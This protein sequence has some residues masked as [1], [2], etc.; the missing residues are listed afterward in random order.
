MGK[1]N[2]I[3]MMTRLFLITAI[4]LMVS[5]SEK[6]N[7]PE[8]SQVFESKFKTSDLKNSPVKLIPFPQEVEW[9]RKKIR[10]KGLNLINSDFKNPNIE[11]ELD[12]IS[13]E[14]GLV[15]DIGAIDL[16][17]ILNSDIQN[18]GYHLYVDKDLILIESSSYAGVFYTLQTLR[19][20]IDVRDGKA[21]IQACI[22]KDY[23][24]FQIRGYMLDVGR[25]YQSMSSL[26]RQLDIMARYKLNVFH[27]HLTDRPAWRIESKIYPELTA[28]EN[29]RPTRDPGKFYSYEEI[30]EL[31]DY[32]K[33]L[34]I[35]VIP[36]IDMPGHSDSF[37]TATGVRM[38]SEKGMEILDNVLNEF[39]FEIPADDCPL[40]HI[41]SD[42]V[43]VPDPEGFISRMV[44]ICE[45]NGR[46]VMIWNP[47][48]P[49]ND[50]VIRQTWQAK[51]VE[52]AD[53]KE[54]DSWNSYVNNDEPH[55]T[56]SKLFFKPVGYGSENEV[57]GSILCLWPDVNIDNEEDAFRFNPV[58]PALLCQSWACWTAGITEPHQAYLTMLP[59]KGTKASE[60]FEAFE[61]FILDHKKKY[62]NDLPF[63]YYKQSGREWKIGLGSSESPDSLKE[64][65][66]ARG[67]TLIFK[68][69]F[70]LGGYFPEAQPG[71]AAIA[72]TVVK[73]E[74][75][76][77]IE[78]LIGFETALRANRT[79]SGIPENGSWD[80][81]GGRIWINGMELPGPE[82]DHPGWKPSK[83]SGWGSTEDQEIPW[84]DEEF[85]W[86]R[87]PAKI[88]I[89]KGNNI[90][91]IIAPYTH[92]Y[93]NWMV[94]FVVTDDEI[95]MSYELNPQ[96]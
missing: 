17:I 53:Y 65:I 3:N 69:R 92:D 8:D 91:R 82:W 96:P 34:N 12:K 2:I 84:R 20:L 26:K 32:A 62:F 6:V 47:G 15:Q 79:Y 29:H 30:R 93:Q 63:P 85:Y 50:G 59:G 21:I 68:D 76:K 11:N 61:E 35:Q 78:V 25:N 4:L 54:V 1:I 44:D 55:N 43:N 36:E 31:I 23:P 89:K 22:I 72:E 19:Q 5:C 51:H 88:K 67:N 58:Y 64:W 41:G 18:E 40:I 38:E 86:T 74:A 24:A 95:I 66:P 83:T 10:T 90:I 71:Q 46:Q 42:E 13:W 45:E 73:S 94:S 39:F 16:K 28:A 75:D 49:A 14:K 77:E 57:I 27:W 70:K 33:R 37:I 60:Y 48:L 80:A 87:E 7:E 81:N 56:V 9:G 52:R